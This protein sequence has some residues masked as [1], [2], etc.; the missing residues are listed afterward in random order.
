MRALEAHARLSA[1]GTLQ[2]AD[3][4]LKGCIM[5]PAGILLSVSSEHPITRRSYFVYW[6][7][8]KFRR[9]S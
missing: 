8:G 7:K 2:V 6:K 5:K 9:V 3:I 1:N 4:G